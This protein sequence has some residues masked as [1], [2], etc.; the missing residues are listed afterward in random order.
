MV[1]S[2]LRCKYIN[3]ILPVTQC[4]KYSVRTIP[5]SETVYHVHHVRFI[6]L[7]FVLKPPS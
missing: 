6:Y 7:S 5:R 1:T 2:S 4:Y 3:C